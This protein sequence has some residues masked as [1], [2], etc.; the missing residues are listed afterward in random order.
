[1]K[2]AVISGN[3]VMIIFKEIEWIHVIESNDEVWSE[4]MDTQKLLQ[5]FLRAILS[6]SQVV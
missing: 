2:N 4:V 5:M 1:M 3:P 6:P